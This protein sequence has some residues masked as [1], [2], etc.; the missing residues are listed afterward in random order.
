MAPVTVDDPTAPSPL[1][2]PP[3]PGDLGGQDTQAQL[4]CSFHLW[5]T[6]AGSEFSVTLSSVS[7]FDVFLVVLTQLLASHGGHALSSML[8]WDTGD[9]MWPLDLEGLGGEPYFATC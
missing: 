6:L 4:G 3:L 9:G 8:Q 1:V 7:S 2:P 5:T